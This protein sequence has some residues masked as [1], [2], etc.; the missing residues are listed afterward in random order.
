MRLR[1]TVRALASVLLWSSVSH[2]APPPAEAE[3]PEPG[4]EETLSNAWSGL[5]MTSPRSG[6]TA[7]SSACVLVFLD[8]EADAFTF[9]RQQ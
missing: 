9:S 5:E 7:P 8:R 4:H 3:R 2:A 1:L 6:C